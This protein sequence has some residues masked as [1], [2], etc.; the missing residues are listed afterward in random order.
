MKV[1]ARIKGLVFFQSLALGLGLL[2]M[3]SCSA[4]GAPETR[5]G[6]AEPAAAEPTEVSAGELEA[7]FVPTPAPTALPVL[8]EARRLN[9]EWPPKLRE[10]ESGLIKMTLEVDDQGNLAPTAEVEGNIVRGETVIIQDLYDTHHVVAEARLDMAGV[11]ISPNGEISEALRPGQSVTFYWNIRTPQV[12]R[13]KG[14]VWLHLLFIP[15]NG[16]EP[17]SRTMVSAQLIDVETVNFLGLGGTSARLLG[18]VGT[19]VGSILGLDNV[20][21]WVWGWFRKR[22]KASIGR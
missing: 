20:I 5:G 7:T 19:L 14:T 17:E 11:E 12:G 3:V 8:T 18:G 13:F 16:E 2:L 1:K 22:S 9:L 10:G 21:S 15:M 6:E 4:A